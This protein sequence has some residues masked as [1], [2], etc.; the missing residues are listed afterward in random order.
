MAP[1]GRKSGNLD[2][3]PHVEVDKKPNGTMYFRYLLP[4]GQ[5]KSLGKDRNEAIK[6]AQALNT[7]L[8]RNPD[9]V[10][11]ILSSVE[12]A[13]KQSNIP[14]F[15]QALDEYEKLHLPK[16]KLAKNTLVNVTANIGKYQ[17]MWGQFYCTDITLLMISEYLKQQ[18]DFQAEKHRSQLIDIWKYL[19]ANGWAPDNIAEKTLKPIRPEKVRT[20][21]SNESLEIVKAVCPPWLK[22]AID[23]AL[24]SIQRR[25]DLVVMERSSIN[26]KDNTMTVLQHK[27]LNY[28][29]PVFIEVDMHPEL[30]EVVL[31]CIEHSMRLRCPYLIATRPD[32]INE[33][34]R[35]AKLHPFAVTE[36]HITK[37]FKKY[38]DLSGAYDHL[39]LNQRPSLHDLRALGIY[40]ITQKY[41]KKY[42]QALAGHATVK[43]TD[44][45]LEGHEAPK[46][47]R[48]SY[49]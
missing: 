30:R 16:K 48:I 34:I 12:K 23:L 28:D 46:P 8:E 45:Y 39:Q 14:N 47:E 29:K 21:H 7:V 17:D 11:K 9:I 35:N 31:L 37:Q 15:G 41:G 44:H 43:M 40:N 42:A 27:S 18:T 26:I 19:V 22:L 49:R 38:R 4:N 2:L 24:H 13:H 32:R 5:R 20:R 36:D 3:P 1:R 33:Q 10:S 25:A 6:A